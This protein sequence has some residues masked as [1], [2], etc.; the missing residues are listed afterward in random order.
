MMKT[1]KNIALIFS[2]LALVA[3]IVAPATSFAGNCSGKAKTADAT[4]ATKVAAHCS[5]KDAK[6]CADKLGLSLEECKKLCAVEG[7][8]FVSLS[9]E[10]M[11]CAGCENSI[12]A[13]LEEIPGVMKVGK[14]SH[15]EGT[16]FVVIDSKLTK[17]EVL[18]NAVLKKGYKVEVVPAVAVMTDG[19]AQAKM[20]SAKAG[21]GEMV[22][23]T[24][25]KTCAKTCASK[26]KTDTK[27]EVKINKTDGTE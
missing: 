3:L 19:D 23:K 18:A 11:T 17:G 20:V 6:A 4:E 14:V 9:I 10:G 15:K 8:E 16:A 22:K 1:Q 26:A 24:C 25:S 13:L 27:T 5:S 7:H 21:C 12:T 2:I